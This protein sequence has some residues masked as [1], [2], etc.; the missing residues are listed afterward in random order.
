MTQGDR[1]RAFCAEQITDMLDD[2]P[3]AV[4]ISEADGGK[5]LYA[6]RLAKEVFLK[7]REEDD[8]FCY[9]V[10][11]YDKP[12]SFCNAG[13]MT[14]KKSATC[15]FLF[16]GGKQTFRLNGKLIDWN[17]KPARIEYMFA[18]PDGEKENESLKIPEEARLFREIAN[19]SADG[20]Y[21][22]GKEN[23]NLLYVN[24]SRNM[25]RVGNIRKG[26]KCYAALHGKDAPCSFCTLKDH[27]PDGKEH[28]M[29]IPGTNQFYATRFRETVWDGVPAYIKYIRDITEEVNTRREKERLEQYFQTIV[30]HLPS[31]IAVV[32]FEEDG[33]MTPEYLSDGFA[34][35]THMTIDEAWRLYE[36]NAMDGVHPDDKETVASKI[37]EYI[38]SGENQYQ[39]TYRLKRGDEGYIWVK[40]TLTM[41]ESRDG[42]RKFYA[43]YHDMTKELQEQERIRQ[44]YNELIV[45]HYR[46]PG[47]NAVVIGHCNITENRIYEIID[48]T[49]SDLLETF[50]MVREDFFKGIASLIVEE[51]ERQMFLSKYLNAPALAAFERG[52]TE[53]VLNCFV[54]LPKETRGRYIRF[55]MNLVETPDT[56]DITGILTVTDITEQTITDRIL[57]QL[58]VASCDLVVDVDL[59]EDRYTILNSGKDATDLPEKSGRHSEKIEHMLKEQVISKDKKRAE[60]MLSEEY[61]L[62]RLE[63]EGTYSFPYSIVSEKGDILTKNM[64]VSAVDLRLGR[65]CLMRSD[66]TDSVREQQG[67]LNMIAYTFE[68]AAFI[69]RNGGN[70]TIYTRQTVLENLAPF[71]A[72]DFD[73]S[74]ESFSEYYGLE[75][76]KDEVKKQFSL[77]TMLSRLE[78]RPAGYDF[79]FPYCK[80]GDLR[81]KQVN[82]L[83]GDENHST[84]CIVRAD[85]TDM[86]ATE[87]ETKDALEKALVLAKKANRA[88]SDF[89]SAMS[90][91]IRT[92]M[93]AI[94]GMTTLATAHLDDKE[95][96]ADCLKKISVSSNHLLS[97]INDILDMSKIERSQI[98]LNKTAIVLPELLEQ[99]SGMIG[100]Q[101]EQAG[102]RLDIHAEGIEHKYFCGDALRINQILINILSNAVKFTPEG[103]R[104][105]FLAEEAGFDPDKKRFRYRF[106]VS[107]TGIG[108][109]EETLLHIFDPFTRG[110]KVEEIEG[111][112]LG[113]SITKG[114]VEL[115]GGTISV[116]S[117]IGEG[118]SFC[119]EL[120]FEEAQKGCGAEDK[121][122]TLSASARAEESLAGRR[123]LIAEDNKLNTEIV[124]G[125]LRMFGAE[126]VA[127]ANGL[128]AVEEF[129]KAQPGTYDAILMDIRMPEMNG[130]EATRTIRRMQRNDAGTIPI[131]AMTANAFA[132]DVQESVDAGMTAHIAKPIDVKLLHA[133]LCEAIDGNKSK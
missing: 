80:D 47:A 83:W 26:E 57:H 45:Q 34:A 18:V 130:Y 99:I 73:V 103:G 51:E 109:E 74:V 133:T 117:R 72:E 44:K 112:G 113:L 6:N 40:N 50:G 91:D 16:C 63:K 1:L 53:Q 114:L 46:T 14:D 4:F 48:H 29:S 61:M 96:V 89:L 86:L 15:D 106:T 55:E 66:I 36:G 19:D 37:A 82:V 126:A 111:T 102:I 65:I 78:E 95:K 127:K 64:T 20:I 81:Y 5:L 60:Q 88:K 97:L 3:V 129:G 118:S 10:A 87:R 132:E 11:G 24:E 93:N 42:E 9:N 85:V 125:I 58:S 21:V 52:D 70:L 100:P 92:P 119:V 79:V 43:V 7:N 90:H 77:E 33:K 39:I 38:A 110:D 12:C 49:G 30:K 123:F 23:Y 8:C 120:E 124:C 62:A 131:I 17:G 94:M 71:S 2:A 68:L 25:S 101:A 128:Q 75:E 76:E 108:M 59:A 104:I 98:T 105:D 121:K 116:E 107:D 22:I 13:Q 41:I 28:E 32:R 69:D 67:L 56:G 122:E 35:M 84:V 31:G 115:M 27:Q 54:K